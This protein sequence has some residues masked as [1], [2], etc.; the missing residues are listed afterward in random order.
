MNHKIVMFHEETHTGDPTGRPTPTGFYLFRDSETEPSV[1]S[2]N[3][4]KY[5]VL[6]IFVK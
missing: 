1:L 2:E 4:D 3:R 5:K 6:I